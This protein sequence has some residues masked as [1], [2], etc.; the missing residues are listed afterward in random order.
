MYF[1][2]RGSFFVGFPF[3][4]PLLSGVVSIFPSSAYKKKACDD[5]TLFATLTFASKR[6]G[7]HEL[8]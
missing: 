1:G 6:T 8:R 4:S 7:K 5:L 3:F 2:K